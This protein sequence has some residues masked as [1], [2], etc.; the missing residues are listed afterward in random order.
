MFGNTRK[1]SSKQQKGGTG[2]V[3]VGTRS[4]T[5][6]SRRRRLEKWGNPINNIQHKSIGKKK[7][8]KPKDKSRV[9][10]GTFKKLT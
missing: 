2:T 10:K 1:Q 6:V 3:S 8:T 9:P 4:Q 5:Q 7:R